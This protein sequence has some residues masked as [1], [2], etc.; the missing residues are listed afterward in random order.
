MKQWSEGVENHPV[1][2]PPKVFSF[3]Y[4][5]KGCKETALVPVSVKYNNSMGPHVQQKLLCTGTA[6]FFVH[7]GE[8]CVSAHYT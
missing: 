5:N 4:K 1:T 8:S 7:K 6:E 3:T 2:K